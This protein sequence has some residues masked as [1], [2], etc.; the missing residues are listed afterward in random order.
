MSPG[1][2]VIRA[3]PFRSTRAALSSGSTDVNRSLAKPS[4]TVQTAEPSGRVDREQAGF[5]QP[6]HQRLRQAAIH[7]YLV[8]HAQNVV[9][10]G[11][12]EILSVH[13]HLPAP[14]PRGT[15][16]YPRRYGAAQR[17]ASLQSTNLGRGAVVR[18]DHET[19]G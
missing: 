3:E 8:C 12:N 2:P 16:I 13:T 5:H 10:H 19:A 15:V 1:A 18:I 14:R 17:M 4:A 11:S 7:F 6:V 9:C